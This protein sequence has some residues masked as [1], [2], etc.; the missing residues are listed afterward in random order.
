MSC[1]P[2]GLEFRIAAR[3][4]PDFVEVCQEMQRLPLD[5]T[6]KRK[7]MSFSTIIRHIMSKIERN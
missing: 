7:L 6:K 1:V 3:L 4:D 2:N 5:I